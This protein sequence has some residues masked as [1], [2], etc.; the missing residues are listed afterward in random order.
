VES[1]ADISMD[2]RRA[3]VLFQKMAQY[4][5]IPF[6]DKLGLGG[7]L[8][9][10]VRLRRSIED[11][12]LTYLKLG[13]FLA[14]RYDILPKEVCDELA[15]LFETVKQ[16]P[17]SE[18][19]AIVESE[20][21]GRVEDLYGKF[22]ERPVASASVSQVH[23][24]WL[25]DGTK[26]AVKVQRAGLDDIFNAD[27]RNLVRMAKI[28]ER[29]GLFGKLSASGMIEEFAV[30][31]L[32]ELDFRIEGRTCEKIASL[33]PPF[34]MAPE[35]YWNLTNRRVLTMEF[36]E[37]VSASQLANAIAANDVEPVRRRIPGFNQQ[38][39]LENFTAAC[40]KQL[41]VD[42]VFHG[43]PHP[44][45][46]LFRG[47][48]R[49]AFIDFG[50][51]G[52]LNAAERE[53]VAGQIESLSLGNIRKSMKFYSQQL[54]ATGETD[55]RQFEIE[56]MEVLGRWRSSLSNPNAPME[57][58]HLARYTAEMIEVSRRNQLHFRLNFL[59]FWRALNNL[60]ATLWMIAPEFDLVQELQV[61]FRSI[62]PGMAERLR[63]SLL[64][65]EVQRDWLQT[66]VHSAR[67][68]PEITALY[69]E[70]NR[71][72]LQATAELPNRV[73]RTAGVQAM[74]LVSAPTAIL[75]FGPWSDRAKWA[76]I[77]AAVAA[78][79]LMMK[80]LSSSRRVR[81]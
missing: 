27:I 38:Q 7:R 2:F 20:L 34:V 31:T 48:N 66:A 17:A 13:Q 24:A 81:E 78:I 58:R 41:F 67:M 44:G 69:S 51:F 43:D 65:P 8:S 4:R 25:K 49:V 60:N 1:L 3:A 57:E 61:F 52:E 36:V 77:V 21:A 30:W 6:A 37:G 16:M 45:N 15:N 71:T 47:D 64:Q 70:Q 39:S 76:L 55:Y 63:E 11:L 18:A 26:V 29:L 74:A 12:G 46:V 80:S 32:R 53:I 33:A 75:L 22:E 5:L 50:I 19:R 54:V 23:I 59:L 73:R 10:A 72:H 42:G 79:I 62:R 28:A 40:F 68:A 14:L 35:V 9:F 56:A